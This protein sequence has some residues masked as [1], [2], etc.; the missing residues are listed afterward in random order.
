MITLPLEAP[1]AMSDSHMGRHL[2][3]ITETII[4]S[5]K[6]LQT[7]GVPSSLLSLLSQGVLQSRE[8]A[9]VAICAPVFSS[10]CVIQD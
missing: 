7:P 1:R 4:D 2:L 3:A 9:V 8:G 5:V 6:G 10:S